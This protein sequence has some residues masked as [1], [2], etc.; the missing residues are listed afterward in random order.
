V[1][2]GHSRVTTP[3]KALRVVPLWALGTTP[4]PGAGTS[5]SCPDPNV[6]HPSPLEHVMA[7]PLL[8][9]IGVGPVTSSPT[10]RWT[11]R[12]N[13]RALG[14]AGRERERRRPHAGT[15]V[16]ADAVI[17]ACFAELVPIWGTA[18]AALF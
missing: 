17:E 4:T 14:D 7:S 5:G 3:N 8:T 15:G 1:T 6:T 11:S 9:V 13:S 12:E 16:Q 18:G 10:W 2:R